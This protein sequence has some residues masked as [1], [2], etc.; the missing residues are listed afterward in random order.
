MTLAVLAYA[1]D[2]TSEQVIFWPDDSDKPRNHLF[3]FEVCRCDLWG[4]PIMLSLGLTILPRLA[5]TDL[6][7]ENESLIDLSDETRIILNNVEIISQNTHYDFKFIE[8][9]VLNLIHAIG[10]AKSLANQYARVGVLIE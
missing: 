2:Q 1:I 10:K 5:D 9:R 8:F 7:C 6:F 4:A 3:G